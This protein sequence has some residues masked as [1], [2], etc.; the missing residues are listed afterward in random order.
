VDALPAEDDAD[1]L[2]CLISEDGWWSRVPT[3]EA[4]QLI[5]ELRVPTDEALA[6]LRLDVAHAWAEA[7]PAIELRKSVVNKRCCCM[8]KQVRIVNPTRRAPLKSHVLSKLNSSCEA[9]AEQFRA[10]WKALKASQEEAEDLRLAEAAATTALE[11]LSPTETKPILGAPEPVKG[12]DKSQFSEMNATEQAAALGLG[13][14][15]AM[16]ERGECPE[17]LEH[18]GW[19]SL[20]DSERHL[21]VELGYDAD[22]WDVEHHE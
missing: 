12:K 18:A 17:E 11:N 21:A 19:W 7:G 8:A 13:W 6:L 16:W 9:A 4:L 20:L 15:H 22:S 1:K 10:R 2:P 14:S 3:D 5:A